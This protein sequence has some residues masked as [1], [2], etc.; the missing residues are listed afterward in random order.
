M[1][2]GVERRAGVRSGRGRDGSA[3]A[4]RSIKCVGGQC[5][6]SRFWIVPEE[7]SSTAVE[8]VRPLL[9]PH[10]H[11]SGNFFEKVA[12]PSQSETCIA[13]ARA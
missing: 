8:L 6:Q 7:D 1:T 4:S 5:A 13:S 10:L 12:W 11:E 3:G 9:G 2:W